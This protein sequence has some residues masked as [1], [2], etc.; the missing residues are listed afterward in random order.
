VQISAIGA[1]SGSGSAY[2]RTKAKG[3]ALVLEHM[4]QAVILRPSIVFGQE[5]GFFNRFAGMAR[6]SPALPM[7]GAKSRFQPVWVDDVAHAAAMAVDGMAKPGIYELGGPDIMNFR[8]LMELMLAE[9]QRRRLLINV[10]FLIASIMG[11][12]LDLAQ[13]LTGGLFTNGILTRDQVQNLR[14]DNIADPDLPGFA[15]LGIN[16]TPLSSVLPD[17]LWRFRK[18]GQYTAIKNSAKNLREG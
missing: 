18:S 9:I 11:G 7:V 17:Y 8:E 5:D 6:L 10:P 1:D 4:P 16:P 15:D 12:A 14:Y 13:T 2:A 3:E